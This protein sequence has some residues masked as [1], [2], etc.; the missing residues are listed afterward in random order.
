MI[1]SYPKT[2]P[3]LSSSMQQ[4]SCK[5]EASRLE[6]ESSATFLAIKHCQRTNLEKLL[7][8]HAAGQ[9]NHSVIAPEPKLT[10][11]RPRQVKGSGGAEGSEVLGVVE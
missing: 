10:S 4:A 5:C 11:S 6:L 8:S 3:L 2:D 1:I 9:K 7:S